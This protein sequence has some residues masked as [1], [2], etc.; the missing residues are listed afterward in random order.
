MSAW[1]CES[2]FTP[3]ATSGGS[4]EAWVTQLMVAAATWPSLPGGQ[5]VEAVGDHAERGLLGIRVHRVVLPP[6]EYGGCGPRSRHRRLFV[7][8]PRP[9]G[10]SPATACSAHIFAHREA[11]R[12]PSART[13]NAV[14]RNPCR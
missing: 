14:R 13:A 11:F 7:A 12:V 5:D 3:I 9:A 1:A 8:A 2:V 10:P 4:N 6:G